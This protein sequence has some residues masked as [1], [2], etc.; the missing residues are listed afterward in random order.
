MLVDV[1][2]PKN[3]FGDL[4]RT[5]TCS[6]RWT[7]EILMDEARNCFRYTGSAFV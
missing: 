4:N 2:A 6:I 3:I 1:G 5:S 7:I